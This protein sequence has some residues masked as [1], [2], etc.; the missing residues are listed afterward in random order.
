MVIMVIILMMVMTDGDGNVDDVPQVQN[1]LMRF[2]LN[3]QLNFALPSA[4]NYV[5]RYLYHAHSLHCQPFHR[6]HH[7]LQV[8]A[9]PT[10]DA[11]WDRMGCSW[12]ALSYLCSPYHLEQ[13]TGLLI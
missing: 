7:Q 3:N 10:V 2:G 1:I 13:R 4:G 6:P 8:H 11:I 5:G 9:V 12:F